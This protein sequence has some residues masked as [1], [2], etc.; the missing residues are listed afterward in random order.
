MEIHKY[1]YITTPLYYV[2]ASPHIGHTYTNIAA[3]TLARFYKLC[4][5]EVYFL[6]GTDEHGR[7]IEKAAQD[8]GVQVQDF[9]NRIVN[10]FK[11]LWQISQVEYTDF[12]RTTEPR[13]I[14]TVQKALNILFEKGDIFSSI[15]KGWYCTPCEMFWVDSQIKKTGRCPDCGRPLEEIEEKNYFFRMS[16]YQNWLIEYIEKHTEFIKPKTRY[17]EVLSFLKNNKLSDLCISRPKE[18]LSWGIELPFDRNYVTYVWFDALLNYISAAGVFADKE[19]FNSCWPA[20]VHFVGKDILRQHAVYWPIMLKALGLEPP[21]QVFAHGWWLM[22]K[23]N[24]AQKMSK[25][26]GN[27][28][29]PLKMIKEFGSDA[30]RFFLLKDVPFGLDGKFSRSAFLKRINSD[31]ANDWGNLIYRTFNMTEKYFQSEIPQIKKTSFEYFSKWNL[32]TKENYLKYMQEIDFYNAL[33][34]VFSYIRKINKSIEEEKPWVMA[35][36]SQIE[37]LKEFIYSLL[38]SIRVIAVY[39]YPFMPK[40]SLQVLSQLGI[41]SLFYSSNLEDIANWN[42]GLKGRITKGRPLFPR[43]N[44]D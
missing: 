20:Y 37:K 28:V 14:E 5:K 4:G 19:K 38:E 44:V 27:T 36:Q 41:E 15:Y 29:D 31:L 7:K 32:E 11:S 42:L 26:L 9:V 30:L 43:I 10:N 12:I 35:R 1:L 40:T 13:H 23:E 17:N 8:S 3:D 16:R 24:Q 6:T 34:A 39:L 21:K 18:R 33:E 25:S 2:N 22:E